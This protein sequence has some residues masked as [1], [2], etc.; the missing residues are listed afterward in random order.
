MH[1][2]RCDSVGVSI[3]KGLTAGSSHVTL[4]IGFAISHFLRKNSAMKS[5]FVFVWLAV[6]FAAQPKP[7]TKSH[8]LIGAPWFSELLEEEDAPMPVRKSDSSRNR[9]HMDTKEVSLKSAKK[10][11]QKKVDQRSK[12]TPTILTDTGNLFSLSLCYIPQ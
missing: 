12:T 2:V 9:N 11:D 4:G 7:G 5:L 3:L 1:A 6:A 8:F 10:V